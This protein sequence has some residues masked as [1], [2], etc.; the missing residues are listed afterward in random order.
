MPTAPNETTNKGARY[1]GSAAIVVLSPL[2]AKFFGL[3]ASWLTVL[4]VSAICVLVYE[5]TLA[6]RLQDLNLDIAGNTARTEKLNRLDYLDALR[7]I[8]AL[9]V[10]V[11]HSIENYLPNLYSQINNYINLGGVGVTAFF[12]ISGYIIPKSLKRTKDARAFAV[13]RFFRLAPFYYASLIAVIV[14]IA[15]H[16]T[17]SRDTTQPLTKSIAWNMTM[18]QGLFGKTDLLGVYWTLAYEWLFYG[19][20]FAVLVTK[21]WELVQALSWLLTAFIGF[22]LVRLAMGEQ[23]IRIDRL[24]FV[25]FF[26]MGF[27]H[28]LGEEFPGFRAFAAALTIGILGMGIAIGA[29]IQHHI[30]TVTGYP[31]IT[32]W[33]VGSALFY[34]FWLVRSKPFPKILTWFG[35]ISFSIYIVHALILLSPHHQTGWAAVAFVTVSSVLLSALTFKVI[36]T[37]GIQLGKNINKKLLSTKA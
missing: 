17:V 11:S 2:F 35:Q 29:G 10:V 31:M 18:I 32:N 23:E 26:L 1:I 25:G 7:G 27:L 14:M 12:I 9:L 37:P 8:A 24:M 33:A 22:Q 19:F 34:G 16:L 21:R 5:F 28:H 36:E 4:V 30:A 13:G 15:V 6:K 20:M 3:G